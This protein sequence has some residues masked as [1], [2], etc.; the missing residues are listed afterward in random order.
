MFLQKLGKEFIRRK[1]SSSCFFVAK[2]RSVVFRG[3]SSAVGL[4]KDDVGFPIETSIRGKLT[5]AFSPTHLEVLNE[6]HMHNVPPNS[7]THFKVVVI[8]THFDE[9]NL[10]KRHQAVN[11]VEN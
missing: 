7:E 10:L 5:K 1:S 2:G 11:S 6:S 9:V 3:M 4:D 8:S